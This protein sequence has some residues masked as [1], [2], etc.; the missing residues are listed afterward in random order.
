MRLW[1]CDYRYGVQQM[2]SVNAFDS[3][4]VRLVGVCELLRVYPFKNPHATATHP[5][6]HLIS[7]HL[8]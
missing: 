4:D 3:L 8:V 6:S 5:S 1:C 2:E 7:S